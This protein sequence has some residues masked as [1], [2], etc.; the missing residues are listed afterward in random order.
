MI[1]KNEVSTGIDT[2]TY[3]MLAYD[4]ATHLFMAYP[5]GASDTQE[6]Y[7]IIEALCQ[8]AESGALLF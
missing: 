5:T 2:K 7:F 3:C 6:A 4:L 1:A 8:T